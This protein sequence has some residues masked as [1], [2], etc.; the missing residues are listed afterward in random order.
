MYLKRSPPLPSNSFIIPAGL[1]SLAY[2]QIQIRP[3]RTT[4][5]GKPF[6]HR[7][8]MY[9]ATTPAHGTA[10]S[11]PQGD[12]STFRHKDAINGPARRGRS[13]GSLSHVFLLLLFIFQ[14][15]KK[16]LFRFNNNNNL[17]KN[18]HAV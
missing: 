3:L 14:N 17:F 16:I 13:A 15:W 2:L 18:V 1:A 10:L 6:T 9:S 8:P 4:C 11:R 7:W 12:T 5:T